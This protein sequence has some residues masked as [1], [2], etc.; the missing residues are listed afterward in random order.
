E[1]AAP[2]TCS[3]TSASKLPPSTVDSPPVHQSTVHKHAS[4]PNRADALGLITTGD[5]DRCGDMISVQKCV[6][7]FEGNEVSEASKMSNLTS[8]KTET[9]LPNQLE[10]FVIILVIMMDDLGRCHNFVQDTKMG[11]PYNFNED[12]DDSDREPSERQIEVLQWLC[13]NC[14]MFNV[15]DVDNCEKMSTK[16]SCCNWKSGG[17]CDR[18]GDMISVQKCVTNFEG[19][20]VSEASKMSNLTGGKSETNLPNQLEVCGEHS[21]SGK[22]RHG[23]FC[24]SISAYTR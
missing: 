24:I 12:D 22:L 7:N 13:V 15:E 6:I 19:N 8:G 10:M 23:F 4:D 21:E 14:T 16:M 20:E 9:N 3:S 17:D 1:N 5:C 2:G 18:C 11:S